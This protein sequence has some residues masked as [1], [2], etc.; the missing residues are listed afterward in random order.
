MRLVLLIFFL[1]S[2]FF[3]FAEDSLNNLKHHLPD[4]TYTNTS[5][6]ANESSL[7]EV[8]K[9]S[10]ERRGKRVETFEFE[11]KEP[12]YQKINSNNELLITWIGHASFLYQNKDPRSHRP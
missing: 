4:G 12:N 10:W 2:P 7:K 6:I 1:T 9:W 11:T 8:L 3:A 5:G